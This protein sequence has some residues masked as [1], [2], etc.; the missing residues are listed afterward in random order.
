MIFYLKNLSVFKTYRNFF[1]RFHQN[2]I[3]RTLAHYMNVRGKSHNTIF[4]HISTSHIHPPCVAFMF[5]IS[6]FSFNIHTCKSLGNK[7]LNVLFLWVFTLST[8]SKCF[9]LFYNSYNFQWK[10]SLES[11]TLTILSWKSNYYGNV[12][13]K[14]TCR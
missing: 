9:L 4:H 13:L 3:E 8:F 12:H 5:V 1:T 6:P 14:V 11:E 2:K 7:F 10:F